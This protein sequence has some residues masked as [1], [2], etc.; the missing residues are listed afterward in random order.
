MWNRAVRLAALVVFAAA[1]KASDV[2]P[3]DWVR[4]ASTR[5][6]P[7]YPGRVP[8][9]V[10][11]NEEHV[12]V[13]GTGKIT[14]ETRKAIKILNQEGRKEAIARVVYFAGSGKVKELRAWVIAP[15]GFTK[16]YGKDREADVGLV[17][18]DLY[19]EIRVRVLQADEPE[20]GSV[21]AYE[22]QLETK[23][24]FTQDQFAF[25]DARPSLTSRYILTLPPGW[26]ASGVVFNHPDVEPQVEGSTYTWE[27]TNLPFR[28]REN[29]G[30]PIS[31]I[32]PRLAVSYFPPVNAN[33]AVVG[34]PLK[35]WTDVSVWMSELEVGQ[36]AVTPEMAAKVNELTAGAKTE[37]GKIA[38]IAGYVQSVKYISIQM[39]VA[40]GG[41]YKP[42]PAPAVFEKNYGDCKDKA[43]L[44]HA[45]LKAAGIPSYLVALYAGDRIFV[46]DN[47]P[48]PQQ[49]NHAIVAV[50]LDENANAPTVLDSPALHRLLIFDPTN[51]MVPFGDLPVYEQ[52]SYALIVA[53]DKGGLVRLPC[54]PVDFN[55]TDIS[56]DG[57]IASSGELDALMTHKTHG[58]SAA[59]LRGAFRSPNPDEGQKLV[60]RWLNNSEKTVDVRK[61]EPQDAFADDSFNL[62]VQFQASNFAQVMQGRLLVFK[63]ALAGPRREVFLREARRNSPVVLNA[64]TFR[65]QVRLKLPSDFSV[66]EM[67]KGGKV[68]ASFGS[69]SCSY[70]VD[71]GE[72]V[73]N[74]E[75]KTQAAVIPAAEYASVRKFF[76]SAQELEDQ[77][78]VLVKN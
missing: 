29:A 51:P 57:A 40:R 61:T 67:P 46:H 43:N 62:R 20:I 18:Q 4:E 69:F 41:G 10:L 76:E 28:A 21:F 33:A 37:Y 63:P 1:L 25:Q 8:A 31:G 17:G 36:D 64:E 22:A 27:L 15:S 78:V 48:S 45:L 72:L 32:A 58:Q 47:W 26:T 13:D 9:A 44:M 56:V 34:R 65:K 6:V 23:T 60:E 49:F 55:M 7:S 77:P 52:G 14:T 54:T 68:E 70:A 19:N 5:I 50:R 71:G 42:H 73:L 39:N 2:P 24:L 35:T 16:S 11:L 30:P 74:Q 75:L 66:D 59:N 3:P 12:L 38:A 53:G